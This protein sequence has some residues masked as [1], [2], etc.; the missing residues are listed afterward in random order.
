[1]GPSSSPMLCLRTGFLFPVR[2]ICGS[3]RFSLEKHRHSSTS[4]LPT[5]AAAAAGTVAFR[6]EEGRTLHNSGRNFPDA[7]RIRVSQSDQNL[8][9]TSTLTSLLKHH[10]KT[11]SLAAGR[12]LHAFIIRSSYD[13]DTFLG[14]CLIDMYGCC[15][16]L[17]DA[18]FIFDSLPNPNVYSW[19]VL[20]HAYGQHA[21]L[22]D[23]RAIFDKIP[24]PDVCSWNTLIKLISQHGG[25]DDTRSVFGRMPQRNVVSWNAMIA[26]SVRPKEHCRDA[27]YFFLQMQLEGV[28][29]D[30]FTYVSA[31]DACSALGLLDTGK[32]IHVSVISMA[33]EQDLMVGTALVNMYGK[34]GKTSA[35]T[36]VFQRMPCPDAVAWT[37]MIAAFSHNEQGKEALDLFYMMLYKGIKADKITYVC[38]LDACAGFAALEE[39][40]EIHSTVVQ[41]ELDKNSV[42]GTA[43]INMYGKGGSLFDASSIFVKM[44]RR[45]AV[46]WT[47]MI[48]VFTQNQEA[49][50]ALNLFYR[51]HFEGFSSDEITFVCALDA[52]AS[53]AALEEGQVIY[54]AIL[55]K[56]LEKDLVVGNNLVN[57]YGKCGC[58][59]ES[60]RVFDRMPSRNTLTWN[61][62]LGVFALN[63]H[64]QEALHLFNEMKRKGI[65]PD[66]VTYL[67]VL[68]ACSH[69]GH[70]EYGRYIFVSMKVDHGV[71]H[72]K[73][74]YVCVID[75]L[76]RAGHLDEAEILINS[77]PFANFSMTWV[78]LLGACKTHG[79]IERGVRAAK[80]C[81]NLDPTDAAPCVA[82]L[83]IYSEAGRWEDAE[84]LREASI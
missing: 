32:M 72:T 14:N 10:G 68:S 34:C 67:C 58:P 29:P 23:A 26:A 25:L 8:H 31:V 19:N 37:A 5:A 54:S 21:S 2:E 4:A 48:G 62:M 47:V 33:C 81:F 52:C 76:G 22:A 71:T 79:D 53:L 38:A 83:N 74:H 36:S 35:A 9:G 49:K 1:M 7:G 63:G 82:L 45:D 3:L 69:A 46:T 66:E 59:F 41:L 18:Q 65:K 11:K 24:H 20:L 61:T 42:I 57:M 56:A 80:W 17:K 60:K 27:L 55:D 64:C 75:L 12:L 51:M 6:Q 77:I 84:E 50:E 78:C 70:V 16:S 15:G 44:S 28:Q 43:L 40:K 13:H 73:D 30:K 39:G